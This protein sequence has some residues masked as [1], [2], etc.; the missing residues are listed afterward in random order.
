MKV[1]PCLHVVSIDISF[2]IIVYF[3]AGIRFSVVCPW[4][5]MVGTTVKPAR[6]AAEEQ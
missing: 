5:Y 6:G 2:R 3:G 1:L 4:L